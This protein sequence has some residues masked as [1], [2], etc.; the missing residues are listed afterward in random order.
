M[1]FL[2]GFPP[3]KQVVMTFAAWEAASQES[4][5]HTEGGLPNFARHLME[6][7]LL[8][9]AVNRNQTAF[10]IYPDQGQVDELKLRLLK[11]GDPRL[12]T[13]ERY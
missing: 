5:R 2:A 13:Q 7:G 8:N 4:E 11:P 10:R 3:L 1:E 6:V 9:Q 12:A